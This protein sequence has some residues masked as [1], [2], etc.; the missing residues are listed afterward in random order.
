MP[1]IPR[2]CARGGGCRNWQPCPKH[3]TS[4]WANN[5][6]EPLPSDWKARKK[7]VERRDGKR[8][9]AC[10]EVKG[11]ELDHILGRAKGGTHELA[12]LQLLCHTC[13]DAKTRRDK[14]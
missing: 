3:P 6:S 4:N 5:K 2:R 10:G 11:L 1:A 8:C 13:H 9:R 12:N 7:A 14:K